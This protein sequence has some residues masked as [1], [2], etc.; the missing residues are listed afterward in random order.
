MWRKTPPSLPFLHSFIM[1]DSVYVCTINY[2]LIKKNKKNGNSNK[3][4]D[5]CRS[6]GK[7]T[8]RKSLA[9]LG[10]ARTYYAMEY[11]VGRLAYDQVRKRFARRRKILC[12][13]GSKR[14]QLWL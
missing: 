12:Q 3:N 2:S 1:E 8:Y 14:R 5:N 9:I 4:D 10:R 6:Y 11:C 13:N 7:G